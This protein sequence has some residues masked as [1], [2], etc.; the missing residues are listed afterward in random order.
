[1]FAWKKQMMRLTS[2]NVRKEMAGKNPA[3]GRVASDLVLVVK[4]GNDILDKLS[5]HLRGSFYMADTDKDGVLTPGALTKRI[6]PLLAQDALAYELK[7]AGYTVTIDHAGNE[8]SAI[9]LE[10][11]QVNN[12]R[13]CLEEGGT[14]AITMR[15]QFHPEEGQLDPLADKLQQ[16]VIVTL[17]PPKV[18]F[19]QQRKTGPDLVD[20]AEAPKEAEPAAEPEPE[21]AAP[22]RTSKRSKR[23]APAGAMR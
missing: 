8:E 3:D 22:A 2:V 11:A 20:F 15:V 23:G 19:D 18:P 9:V 16:E 5:P 17:T 7:C 21:P 13:L 12:F 10:S 4:G 6:H 1:M 14:V